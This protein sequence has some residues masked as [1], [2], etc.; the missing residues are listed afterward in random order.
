MNELMLPSGTS[1]DI[2]KSQGSELIKSG[3]LPSSIK[4]PEQFMAIVL[5]GRELGVPPM[6]ACAHIHII[7]GK[8]TM[9][10]ELMLCQI[11]KLFPQTRI[12]YPV[13]SA[14]E[15]Q[16]KVTRPGNEPSLFSYTIEEAANAG[17][18][19]NPVWK[20]YPRA[21]LHARA[22]SEMARSL[23]PDAISGISYTPEELGASVSES[24][25]VIDI[26]ATPSKDTAPNQAATT[27]IGTAIQEAPAEPAQVVTPA[28]TIGKFSIENPR[29]V[30]FIEQFLAKQNAAG[31]LKV[32]LARMAGKDYRLSVVESEWAR[33]NPE[34][35]DAEPDLLKEV[36]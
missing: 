26:P 36:F 18:L 15:C 33:I 17:L 19:R 13:R 12:S 22:V 27:A 28:N 31:H 11:L 34:A 6:Q 30:Q 8:P 3:F 24:G 29:H 1:W 16:I 20:S 21:M 32:L 14:K 9:S 35:P 10:A 2:A 7:N 4:T 23:F 5:K 25:D